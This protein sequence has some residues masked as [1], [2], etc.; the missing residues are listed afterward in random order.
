MHLNKKDA[1]FPIK[2]KDEQK[3]ARLIVTIVD[4]WIFGY[5]W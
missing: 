1:L 3:A 4:L 2:W 5:I